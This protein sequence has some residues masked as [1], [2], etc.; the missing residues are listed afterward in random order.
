M[1]AITQLVSYGA[2]DIYLC[3]NLCG[4]VSSYVLHN[5][6]YGN[7]DI[8]WD[9]ATQLCDLLIYVCNQ[10]NLNESFKQIFNIKLKKYL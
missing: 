4:N 5:D 2:Q 1:G 9:Y 6:G 10:N 8:G 7:R 3:G